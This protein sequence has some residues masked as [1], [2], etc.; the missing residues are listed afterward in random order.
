MTFDRKAARARCEAATP[1]P[2]VVKDNVERYMPDEEP[3]RIV[4]EYHW[5]SI[6][7]ADDKNVIADMRA[8]E[9]EPPDST[10]LDFIAHART[11]LPLALDE[12]DEKDAEIERL[13]GAMTEAVESLMEEA[14]YYPAQAGI[15]ILTAALEGRD[16]E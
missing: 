15:N 13:R 9:W 3:G 4:Y 6:G 1:G 2:W 7:T 14:G 5:L 11:D 12:L 10:D 16:S 8:C